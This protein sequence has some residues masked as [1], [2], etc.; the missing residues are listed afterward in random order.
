MLDLKLLKTFVAVGNLLHFARAADALHSTQPGVTQHIA[1]L[2]AQLGVQ[3]F[4]RSKRSVS[5]TDAGQTLLRHAAQM[6]AL[7]ERMQDEAR[8]FADGYG[9]QLA[10]GLS[11]V[12]LH[13]ALP[14]RIEL[15]RR[16]HPLIRLDPIVE[17]ADRLC[18]LIDARLVD[19]LVTTL[20]AHDAALQTVKLDARVPMGV[21]LP[22]THR[23]ACERKV[24]IGD[25]GDEPFHTVPRHLHPEFYD[26]LTAAV[27]RRG[28]SIRI[29]GH[30]VS[31]TN[32]LAR[33]AL[34][35][36]VALVPCA[37]AGI[38]TAGVKVVPISDRSLASLQT[39]VVYPRKHGLLAIE[40]FVHA[41]I[42]Q[43]KPA[44]RT[45]RSPL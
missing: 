37:Y 29:A 11:S 42:E 2:E 1:R 35:G 23:L 28:R 3:L 13:S 27:R 4:H 20:P 31:F 15:F 9:G 7:A 22:D 36:G 41:M 30:E 18:E 12:I 32:L 26:S 5:L 14:E 45:R 38:A 17:S 25:L 21:A 16:R 39:Y 10:I 43:G 33:V 34:G 8:A 19:V 40:Q 24:S 44:K 6:L